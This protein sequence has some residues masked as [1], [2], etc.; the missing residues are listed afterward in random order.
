MKKILPF[1]L[2]SGFLALPSDALA[3]TPGLQG[4]SFCEPPVSGQTWTITT[5]CVLYEDYNGPINADMTLQTGSTLTLHSG[6]NLIW[7]PGKAITIESGASIIVNTGSQITQRPLCVNTVD[8]AGS[9]Y[10]LALTATRPS[11]LG[12]GTVYL[13]L[14][15]QVPASATSACSTLGAGYV[16]ATSLAS[17]DYVSMSA[18]PG[19]DTG[20][21]A[22]SYRN[23]LNLGMSISSINNGVREVFAAGNLISILG[24]NLK[25]C[26]TSPCT[27]GT[28]ADYGNLIVERNVGIGTGTPASPL[29]VGSTSQ[30]Q[31]NSTGAI[32]AAT[33]ITSSGTVTFSGLT[34]SRLVT[35]TTGGQLNNS[36][37]SANT[38]AT[39]SDETG[40]GALVFGTAP[41]FTTSITSPLVIGGTST[42]ADLILKTTSGVGASG[43]DMIFQVG[44]NGGT[45]A[46][47]ILN[48]GDVGI[49][50]GSPASKLDI[51]AGSNT[52]GIRLRGVAETTE[53]ADIYVGGQGQLVLSTA[54]TGNTSAYIEADAE[55]DLYGLIIRDSNTG[56]TIWGNLYMAD[57]A[58]D[59]LNI[60]IGQGG[61][62]AGLVIDDDDQVGIGTTTPDY[63]LELSDATAPKLALSDTGLAHGI[64]TYAQTDS[65]AMIEQTTDNDGGVRIWGFSDS[66]GQIP[67]NII[68]AFGSTDPTDTIPAVVLNGAK[69]SGTALTT[70]ADAETLLAIRN[71]GTNMVTVLGSGHVNIGSVSSFQRKLSVLGDTV[72]KQTTNS[73]SIRAYNPSFELIDKDGVGN[74][75]FGLNDDDSNN[76]YI[77]GG[78]SPSQGIA[79]NIMVQASTGNVGIGTINPGYTL[80]VTG[81]AWVTSGAWSGSDLRWKKD[82]SPLSADTL[83]KVDQLRP[84][85]F[86][87]RQDE[88]PDNHFPDGR[89]I[90]FIAQDVEKIYPELVTTDNNGYKGISYEKMVPVLTRAIQEQQKQIDLLREEIQELKK[91]SSIQTSLFRW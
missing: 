38:A 44:N 64:T 58:V 14:D 75:Y 43:A 85:T 91:D 46:M 2:L 13:G 36:I 56:S 26:I 54:N 29:S 16:D 79:P 53:I 69:K 41:T 23:L 3:Q 39:V 51:D 28:P 88:Y 87:W 81:T 50:T 37:T 20:F 89:Q 47:R 18:T 62:T 82:V 30:F 90:G 25:I 33:G 76:L 61:A 4:K 10:A 31:V 5:D 15:Q 83:A 80:T 72:T 9:K 59:Y 52:T 12:G 40:S 24:D 63:T 67:L 48:S 84:V 17:R 86:N 71:N 21:L 74:W 32:A 42:T 65:F 55:D 68:G 19:T 7:Y 1:L 34:A 8:I 22:T 27:L 6:K 70:L 77:G 60:V 66:V 57:A 45:E 35:T 11:D 78:Y 49:G 73:V